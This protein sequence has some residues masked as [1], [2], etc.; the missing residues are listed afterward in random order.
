MHANAHITAHRLTLTSDFLPLLPLV[1]YVHGV[2]G[3]PVEH[4]VMFCK[5]FLMNKSDTAS[6]GI[7]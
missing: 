3:S 1:N 7:V 5:M 6:L 2:L 4:F